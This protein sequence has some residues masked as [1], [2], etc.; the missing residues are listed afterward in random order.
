[1]TLAAH[2]ATRPSTAPGLAWRLPVALLA[3]CV[4]SCTAVVF[5]YLGL[6]GFGLAVQEG[7]SQGFLLAYGAGLVMLLIVVLV[8]S[9]LVWRAL[10]GRAW[11]LGLP[12]VALGPLVLAAQVGLL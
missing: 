9:A 7:V 4:M 11:W 2:P 12:T 5:A 8:G 3:G 1:M 6:W 10:L